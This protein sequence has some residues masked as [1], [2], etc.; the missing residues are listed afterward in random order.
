MIAVARWLRRRRR[1]GVLLCLTLALAGF[2]ELA[3]PPLVEQWLCA[4]L[5]EH[6]VNVDLKVVDVGLTRTTVQQISLPDQGI[7]IDEATLRYSLRD[8][9]AGRIDAVVL[10]EARWA[11][12]TNTM[13]AAAKLDTD[14]G[15]WPPPIDRIEMTSV[16]AIATNGVHEWKSHWSGAVV[17]E[18]QGLSIDLRGSYR[19]SQLE[20]H[21]RGRGDELAYEVAGSEPSLGR[22]V[23]SGTTSL[24]HAFSDAS[25]TIPFAFDAD[26][27]ARPLLSRGAARHGIAIE[28][29][30][31][32][33][34]SARGDLDRVNE[35]WAARV[36]RATL[37]TAAGQVSNGPHHRL[38]DVVLALELSGRADRSGARLIV[39]PGSSIVARRLRSAGRALTVQSG[40]RR[41]AALTVTRPASAELSF[42]SAT[43]TTEQWSVSAPAVRLRAEDLAVRA[44]ALHTVIAGL[45]L[46]VWLESTPAGTRAG[47]L[48][49]GVID[50]GASQLSVGGTRVALDPIA[51][52]VRRSSDSAGYHSSDHHLRMELASTRPFD[53]RAGTAAS[54]RASIRSLEI[55]AH[56]TLADAQPRLTSS[57]VTA[58]AG[59]LRHEELEIGSLAVRLPFRWSGTSGE[60]DRG[61]L[62]MSGATW[63]GHA[64]SPLHGSIE[65][66][67]T[68]W[69][70]AGSTSGP[71]GTPMSVTATTGTRGSAEL[72]IELEA[73][74]FLVR[75]GDRAGEL[76]KGL[77]GVDVD[78]ALSFDARLTIA[79]GRTRS[80]AR[81][82]VG[83]LA[84]VAEDR[85]LIVRG[86]TGDVRLGPRGTPRPGGAQSLRWRTA[87]IGGQ[88]L[89]RGAVHFTF[90]SWRTLHIS[91][92]RTRVGK[93]TISLTPFTVDLM[94]PTVRT[95]VLM[96]GLD[97]RRWLPI[98]SRGKLTGTGTFDGDVAVELSSTRPRSLSLGKGHIATRG[99][100]RLHVR[101]AA[102]LR[103]LASR[104]VKNVSSASMREI[105]KDRVM[106]ALAD[107]D[108][109]DLS[110]ELFDGSGPEL[111]LVARGRGRR[112][113][114]ELALTINATGVADALAQIP[115]R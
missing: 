76:I 45:D 95:S 65:R 33:Q 54:N 73:P 22:L 89:G 25:A 91:G 3:L 81:L 46:P 74:R 100:G 114:Q 1:L 98:V 41:A 17:F 108:Y 64:L 51:L 6:G 102:L 104:A 7:E 82:T 18:S 56:A 112:V 44:E 24:E 28:A 19:A 35:H 8:L 75:H 39:E 30:S 27:D 90:P 12:D 68:H 109:Q 72:V 106:T 34:L 80:D 62:R 85:Q 103:G 16:T 113:A 14:R 4:R 84:M 105:I 63:R 96:A 59:G 79:N 57:V 26:I 53:A 110:L 111:T 31:T 58:E 52:R 11:L 87:S 88:P 60:V 83:D 94:A 36:A 93:G 40:T 29:F 21:V 37:T 47:F 71:N 101:D 42:D 61:S 67:Q 86:L 5:A 9:L 78:G 43:G 70:F 69:R 97:M 15:A 38:R 50:T 77:C 10:G 49:G 55:A 66:H 115:P 2:F 23:A 99:R 48:A 107:F 92:A 32:L 20:L 13:H